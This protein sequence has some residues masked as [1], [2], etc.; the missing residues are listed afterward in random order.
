MAFSDS[1][2]VNTVGDQFTVDS[3]SA[4]PVSQAYEQLNQITSPIA[5]PPLGFVAVL[6][7]L[8]CFTDG[9]VFCGSGPTALFNAQGIPATTD[10]WLESTLGVNS[11]ASPFGPGSLIEV[12]SWGNTFV[13]YATPEPGSMMLLGAGLLALPAV[14]RRLAKRG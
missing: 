5:V 7:S 10:I 12:T 11:N 9:P 3:H 2:S 1:L 8:G 6:D 14:R 4:P 13:S